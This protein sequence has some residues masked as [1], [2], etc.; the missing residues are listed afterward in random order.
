[1]MVTCPRTVAFSV[2]SIVLRKG[3]RSQAYS[4]ISTPI[5]AMSANSAPL[6][7]TWRFDVS[8]AVLV[9]SAMAFQYRLFIG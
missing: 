4:T 2:V 3:G 1:M 8:W 9:V 7:M 6:T 5:S